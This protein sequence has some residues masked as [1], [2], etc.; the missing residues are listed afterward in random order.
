MP[1]PRH[2]Y[3]RSPSGGQSAVVDR[4]SRYLPPLPQH[5]QQQQQQQHR[6]RTPTPE[7]VRWQPQPQSSAERISVHEARLMSAA[8]KAAAVKAASTAVASMVKRIGRTPKR[9]LS[10]HTA[11]GSIMTAAERAAAMA[12]AGP[13][14]KR[15]RAQATGE[16]G[17][18]QPAKPSSGSVGP[19]TCVNC[20]TTK[21]PLWRRDPRGQPICNACGLYLKSYGRMR[22]MSLKRA[23]RQPEDPPD[24]SAGASCGG[25]DEGTCPGNG[26]CNGKGGGPSCDGCPAYNQKHLPHSTRPIGVATP[27]GG[28]RRLTAAERAAAIANG[29]ATDEHGNIVGPIPASA[30]GP[31]R[32]PPHVAE[33]I[34][35]AVA[36]SDAAA[37]GAAGSQK[38]VCFNCGTDYTP[39]WRR[40]ADGH[41]TCNACGLYYK[42]HGRHRPISMKR[43]AIKRRR[44]GMPQSQTSSSPDNVMSPEPSATAPAEQNI[45][46][47]SE[48][49]AA[50][51]APQAAEPE[52]VMEPVRLEES[53]ATAPVHL[54]P[55]ASPEPAQ[56]LVAETAHIPS[57]PTDV[58]RCR[59]EL[60]RECTRLQSLL[61]RSTSLLA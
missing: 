58:E 26:T 9:T 46:T 53:P 11:N 19:M 52:K 49:D 31:G 22:P 37:K 18:D 38:S 5:R 56:P 10:Q 55:S 59:E 14:A 12:A 43:D 34:R 23:Q 33:A 7:V 17:G 32:I 16:A 39:L 3:P 25:H 13:A 4:A 24:A 45:V 20:A 21:T 57:D 35:D 30:I 54:P 27:D 60:Q 28:V 51:E 6:H 44:R 36:P 40:D 42:L 61:E 47:H 50:L 48:P 15:G 1:D 8:Q 41:I 29:A 2:Y